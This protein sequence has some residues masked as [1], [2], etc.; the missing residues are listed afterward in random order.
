[1][2]ENSWQLCRNRPKSQRVCVTLPSIECSNAA[3]RLASPATERRVKTVG[4]DETESKSFTTKKCV[5]DGFKTLRLVKQVPECNQVTKQVCDSKPSGRSMP[6]ER[7][8][9]PV[10][11]TAETRPGRSVIWWTRLLRSRSLPTPAEIM[12]LR[13]S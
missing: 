11:R 3:W 5:P 12:L 7:R 6:R 13:L 1:M 4:C 8:S 9:S 10:T 2:P